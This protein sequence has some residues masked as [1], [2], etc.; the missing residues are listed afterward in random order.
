MVFLFILWVDL[1]VSV[2]SHSCPENH[3][4]HHD[5]ELQHVTTQHEYGQMVL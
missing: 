3:P 2:Y 1:F 5:M 4:V